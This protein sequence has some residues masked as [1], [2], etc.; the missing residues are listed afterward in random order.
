VTR[1]IVGRLAAALPVLFIVSLLAFGLEAITPGDPATLLLQASGVENVTPEAVAAKRAELRLDDPLPLR[2]LTWIRGAVRGDFGRSF[3]SYTPVRT[4]YSQRIANTAL[5]AGCAVLLAALIAIPLG[6]LA[7]YRRG[8]VLDAIAQ[9]VAVVGAAVPGFW[10]AFVLIF[11]F[12]ARLHWLPAFGTPTARGVVLPAIVLALA[13]I[14]ILTRL[15]RAAMLDVLKREFVTVA[16]AKGL[17]SGRVARVHVLP[18]VAVPILTVLGLEAAH[19]ITGAAV[20]EYVF[21]WPGIG[22]LAV[23]AA[24]QRDTPVIVGFAVAAGL[25]FVTANLVVDLAIAAFDPRVRSV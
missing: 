13:N 14:A 15:T 23:D 1:Y 11:V 5:L 8:G 18:N 4:L 19:L 24:L 7:A 22:K 3:R 2:Y 12:A 21:A 10:I 25:I 9:C 17:G 16:R 6:T 20:V